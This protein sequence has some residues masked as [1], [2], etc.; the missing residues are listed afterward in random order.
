[1][2]L[3]VRL[4]PYCSHHLLSHSWYTSGH[5]VSELIFTSMHHLTELS[6]SAGPLHWR[7]QTSSIA[8]L[9]SYRSIS[10]F[11]VYGIISDRSQT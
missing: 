6:R 1:M 11:G 8:R 2:S 7:G 10:W 3:I 5:E 4:T 9:T